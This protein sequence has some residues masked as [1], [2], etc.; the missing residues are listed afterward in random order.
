MFKKIL[1]QKLYAFE[2]SPF[3]TNSC[4]F[5]Y[6]DVHSCSTWFAEEPLVYHEPHRYRRYAL[7]VVIG[8]FCHTSRSILEL[9]AIASS[10][11]PA[12]CATCASQ[13]LSRSSHVTRYLIYDWPPVRYVIP[14]RW[15]HSRAMA[16]FCPAEW[17]YRDID[18]MISSNAEQ[19]GRLNQ[20]TRLYLWLRW[21]CKLVLK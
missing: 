9:S 6:C 12:R 14:Q 20:S 1:P 15:R 13:I 18:R 16:V 10:Q 21:G 2:C 11:H 5:E 7:V 3:L 4:I 19:N 17:W 8:H